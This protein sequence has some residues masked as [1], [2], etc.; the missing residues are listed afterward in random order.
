MP[1]D[2]D[3]G[4]DPED[5]GIHVTERDDDS[6]QR[7][8]DEYTL[9]A[10][11]EQISDAYRRRAEPYLQQLRRNPGVRPAQ[12]VKLEIEW[13]Q[14]IDGILASHERAKAYERAARNE[15]GR[16]ARAHE[17][18]DGIQSMAA[19]SRDLGR[20][21]RYQAPAEPSSR[22][23]TDVFNFPE[24][25]QVFGSDREMYQRSG[26]ARDLGLRVYSTDGWV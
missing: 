4:D 11:I 2:Q 16:I 26:I 15:P 18:Q 6:D 22:A 5:Y 12:L 1:G 10:Q 3:P 17:R 7:W 20:G 19:F 13:R 9:Q 21:A 24:Q 8:N 14:R 23:T 25:A